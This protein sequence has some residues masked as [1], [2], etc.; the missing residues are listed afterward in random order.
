MSKLRIVLADDHAVVREGLR[1]LINAQPDM[2][3]VGEAADGVAA[4]E[5]VEDREPD[6]LIVDISLPVLCGAEVTERVKK[7]CP[8]VKVLALTV[9][10]E[11]AFLRQILG[12]GALGYVLK[13]SAAE[14]LIQAI[15]TV[16]EGRVYL[17]PSMA[18]QLVGG[19]VGKYPGPD[20]EAKALLSDREREVMRDLALGYSNKEIASRMDVSVKTVETYK[21]RS[22]EKLGFRTRTDI[23]R[24][25]VSQGW[26]AEH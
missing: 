19:F 9:H 11:K 26:L 2:E 1:S 6:V 8:D 20:P 23:V 10:E 5:T 24:Y 22:M 12:A 21:S 16:A 14:E 25:A 4:Y 3:V 7:K 13:R 17:D 15:R 18:G